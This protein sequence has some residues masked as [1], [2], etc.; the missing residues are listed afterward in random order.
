MLSHFQ[1]HAMSSYCWHLLAKTSFLRH[2]QWPEK[3]NYM[4]Q[5]SCYSL[6]LVKWQKTTCVDQLTNSKATSPYLKIEQFLLN[7]GKML[8]LR[9]TAQ[10]CPSLDKE[11]LRILVHAVVISVSTTAMLSMWGSPW[12]RP[13][14]FSRLRMWQPD[15][16]LVWASLITFLQT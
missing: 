2:L 15:W 8:E 3:Y 5:F 9:C 12:V 7:G 13:G 1:P 14:Y 6:V 4:L 11:S 16:W 10:L